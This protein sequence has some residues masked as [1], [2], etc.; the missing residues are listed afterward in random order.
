MGFELIFLVEVAQIKFDETLE[1]RSRRKIKT[2]V[3]RNSIQTNACDY[4][5]FQ[6]VQLI[7]DND[8]FQFLV[9]TFQC[10]FF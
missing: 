2:L 8:H 1:N 9:M 10:K 7:Y 6:I 3:P 5:K 4:H